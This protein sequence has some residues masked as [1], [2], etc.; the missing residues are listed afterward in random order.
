VLQEIVNKPVIKWSAFS[1]EKFTSAITKYN[2][3]ST[4]ELDKLLWKYLKRCIKDI[5]CLKKFIDIANTCIELRHWP[6]HFKVSTT[7]IIP[8]PN[9]ESYD[10]S[11]AFCPIILLN[12]LG[13]LVEKVIG[14][15]LQF[16]AIS[17]N[18][19]HQCQ[20][21]SLKQCST[22]DVGIILTHAIYLE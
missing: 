19:I 14:E 20:L 5:T 15:R 2:N 22:I 8:K 6:L 21:G 13:K 16:L 18:F 12:T 10:T 3:S 1:E 11:K 9:K 7:I 17:N 4:S